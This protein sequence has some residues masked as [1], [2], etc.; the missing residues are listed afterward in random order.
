MRVLITGAFGFVL[1]NYVNHLFETNQVGGLAVVDSLTYA[2][3]PSRIK[4]E[5]RSKVRSYPLDVNSHGLGVIFDQ[6]L[7]DVVIIGHAESHVD[8]SIQDSKP[9]WDSN[10][11]GVASVLD[12][13]KRLNKNTRVVHI[14]TDEVLGSFSAPKMS[15]FQQSVPKGFDEAWPLD[16]SSPYSA[17]KAAGE[18][19][20]E[21]Y[22]KTH[23]LSNV[24][25]VRPTNMY[26]P[27]QHKEKLL[28]KVIDLISKD[29]EI[30]VYGLGNQI[31]DWLF[32]DN[33]CT[34][35]DHLIY[36]HG[37]K[38]TY[39]VS[40]MGERLTNLQVISMIGNIM[41][42]EPRIKFVTDRPAHDF[43]YRLDSSM[44]RDITGW[45]PQT[46]LEEGLRKTVEYY[47]G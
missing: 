20:V 47:I 9:F 11:K 35:L 8:N 27:R 28:P 1:S 38:D 46:S 33:F 34:A 25:I 7:P 18:L 6:E 10:V 14:S 37:M 30:P 29:E 32:V 31:R 2:A 17:S 23:E 15:E 41:G 39:H 12:Q 44:F 3:D 22:K 19:V 43:E 42:K 21:S 16:P 24:A 40:A 45:K 4:E 36:S 13:V 5:Y 26:G